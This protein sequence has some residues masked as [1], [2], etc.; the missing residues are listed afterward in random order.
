MRLSKF[1]TKFSQL[2]ESL[3]IRESKEIIPPK[4]INTIL[5][6]EMKGFVGLKTDSLE[7]TTAKLNAVTS[8]ILYTNFESKVDLLEDISE[9]ERTKYK[10]EVA[11]S[12]ET[13][14]GQ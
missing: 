2:I 14:V 1:D 4:F 3:K 10:K 8:N 7:Q 11:N 9:E 5:L 13:V 6:N 12:I